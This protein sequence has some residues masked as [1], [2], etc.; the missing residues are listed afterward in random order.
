MADG[1]TLVIA[2]YVTLLAYGVI[3]KRTGEDPEWDQRFGTLKRIGKVAGPVLI[4]IKV[5]Q[6]VVFL[7]PQ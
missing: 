2:V 1:L 5:I 4:V 3:G 7:T 6:L